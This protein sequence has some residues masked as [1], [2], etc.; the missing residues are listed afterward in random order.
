LA[1]T[2][3][4]EGSLVE[5]I[6]V[7]STLSA[8]LDRYRRAFAEDDVEALADLVHLPCLVMGR[9]V[10]ALTTAE[11]LRESLARQ[12]ERHRE[13]GVTSASFQ[14]LGHRR[15]DPRYMTVDVA[16]QMRD[17][18]EQ[19]VSEFATMYVL[20]A[21]ERGWKIVTVAPLEP[22][23]MATNPTGAHTIPS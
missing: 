21:P 15:V 5:P 8:F 6:A 7:A 18:D 14:V 3:A 2:R 19:L 11:Q 16:W 1:P 4:W 13:A 22:G 10:V 17:V 23:I 12:L 9:Q 20:T